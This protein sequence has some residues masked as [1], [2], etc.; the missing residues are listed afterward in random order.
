MIFGTT[1]DQRVPFTRPPEAGFYTPRLPAASFY[2]HLRPF[3]NVLPSMAAQQ[4]RIPSPQADMRPGIVQVERP[5]QS[6]V[7]RSLPAVAMQPMLP[8][9]PGPAPGM[10]GFGRSGFGSS[11]AFGGGGSPYHVM[12]SGM[13]P[14][15]RANMS[16][17]RVGVSSAGGLVR[18]MTPS[19]YGAND[20]AGGYDIG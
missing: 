3:S 7:R 2:S 10:N 15:V 5:Q 14:G 12:R 13:F 6:G 1:P 19:A 11:A 20:P 4:S 9:G 18:R 17:V 8:E 16:N